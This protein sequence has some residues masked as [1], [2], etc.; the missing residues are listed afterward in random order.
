VTKELTK[1][2]LESHLVIFAGAGVSMSTPSSL[3]GWKALNEDIFRA[4]RRRQEAFLERDGWLEAFEKQLTD[5]RRNDVFPPDYQAQIVEEICGERYFHGLRSLDVDVRNRTHDAIASLAAG[6]AV[7][8]I[9]TT[10]FDRLIEL[11]LEAQGVAYEVAI[12]DDGYRRVAE[13]LRQGG[14]GPLPVIKIHGCVSSP[15]SMIDTLKQRKK[16]RSEAIH[17]CLAPLFSSYWLYLGFSAAD[18]ETDRNYLGMI[19]G[20]ARGLGATYVAYR[21]KPKAES[22]AGLLMAAYGD[23]RGDVQVMDSGEFL[24][25]VCEAVN[26]R[27][28]QFPFVGGASGCE[29]YLGK[30]EAW[31]EGLSV[32]ATGLCLAAMLQAA[33]MSESAFRIMDRLMRKER[34]AGTPDFEALQLNYGRLG[35][36]FGG[37][38]A[39]PDMNGEEANAS[40]ECRNALLRLSGT[41]YRFA[42]GGW[43]VCL[44]LWM[45]RGESAAASAKRVTDGFKNGGW[46]GA[47]PRNHEETVDA[48]LAAA[49]A[50]VVDWGPGSPDDLFSTFELVLARSRATGDVVRTARVIAMYLLGI[51]DTSRDIH[52]LLAQYDG[53]FDEARRVG[54]Q[55]A[56]AF[57]SLAVGR[58][59]VGP[60]GLAMGL[61][62][63]DHATP[64]RN[65]LFEL[66]QASKRFNQQGADPWSLFA[67]IQMAKA[68]VDLGDLDEA[69]VV[70]RR[71]SEDLSR[72][73]VFASHL[74]EA[75]GQAQE[76]ARH[77]GA[78]ESFR[79][80]IAEAAAS[81][82]W[83]RHALLMRHYGHLLETGPGLEAGSDAGCFLD[84]AGDS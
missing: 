24:R 30:L 37:F 27:F 64:A 58:W 80:A 62:T 53:D 6:G 29:V 69:A 54:D 25:L 15:T 8:A 22:G 77:E 51:A 39:V 66:N 52:P 65:A 35:A 56:L 16:G 84:S 75:L 17:E 44:L 13:R 19:E 63:G 9:V 32:A 4:L 57:R 48:W 61:A 26:V 21:E 79:R 18:L 73:P 3:P 74:S 23:A 28:R 70:G 83:R 81:G 36:A 67:G 31:V 41:R 40:V 7:T 1:A 45:N 14:A 78:A 34:L 49:Q 5:Q 42:A 38:F 76:V 33:G 11:A 68:L 55:V 50:L 82:L 71:C 47:T 59:H 46:A 60:G 2:A 20:A 12:E 43:L 10:N 72:F